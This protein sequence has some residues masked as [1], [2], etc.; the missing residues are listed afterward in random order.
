MLCS[1]TRT[2]LLVFCGLLGGFAHAWRGCTLVSALAFLCSNTSTHS[3]IIGTYQ[4]P[5]ALGTQGGTKRGC[6]EGDGVLLAK[7]DAAQATTLVCGGCCVHRASQLQ[8]VLDTGSS[9]LC[10]EAHPHKGKWRTCMKMLNISTLVPLRTLQASRL[11]WSDV[12]RIA[13]GSKTK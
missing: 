12:R 9:L 7:T 8:C 1:V 6:P 13:H 5:W 4:G 3:T 10:V 11:D 2:C